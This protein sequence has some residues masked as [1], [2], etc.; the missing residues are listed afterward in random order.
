MKNETG[1]RIAVVVA[2]ISVAL[3][4][5]VL[6]GCGRKAEADQGPAKSAR[7]ECEDLVHG[8]YAIS[9]VVVSDTETGESW[10]VAAGADGGVAI[11][12]M[13]TDVEDGAS[14]DGGE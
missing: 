1:W 2:T 9:L 7:Y 8:Y 10:L 6:G 12:R 3:V 13:T 4:S 14:Q 5:A 11:E